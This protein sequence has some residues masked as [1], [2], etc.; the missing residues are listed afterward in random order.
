MRAPNLNLRLETGV[1]SLITR[2]GR[3]QFGDQALR[4]LDCFSSPHTLEEAL[5]ALHRERDGT[6]QWMRLSSTVLALHRAGALVSHP[7]EVR[8]TSLARAYA[9]ARVHV[10]MLNDVRRTNAYLAAIA[11]TV[12]PG[13]VVVDVGTGTGILALAAARAG[14]R[15]VYAIEGS[16]IAD[17]AQAMF[18]QNGF[19][20]RITL[21]RGWSTEVTLPE[22]ADVMVAELVGVDPFG[23]QIAAL[24]ADAKARLLTDRPRLVPNGLRVLGVPVSIPD[25]RLADFTFMPTPIA[26]WTRDYGFDFSPLLRAVPLQPLVLRLPTADARGLPALAEPIVIANTDFTER[27]SAAIDCHADVVATEAGR[28]NGI[29]IY[30][31]LS[32]AQGVSL[33]TAPHIAEDTNHWGNRVLLLPEPLDIQQGDRLR[34]RIERSEGHFEASCQRSAP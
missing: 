18:E 32:L 23:E 22:R 12:Q 29:L 28:L 5:A 25:A 34:V 26:G 7:P 21:V 10:R 4:V 16:G 15:I 17:T 1:V 27:F 8:G 30:F 31:D 13:D 2:E 33:T 6:V 20:D 24:T 14:A 11:S 9:G 19:A 3:V